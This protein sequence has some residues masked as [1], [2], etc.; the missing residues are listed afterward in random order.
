MKFIKTIFVLIV[1]CCIFSCKSY[2]NLKIDS[3][4]FNMLNEGISFNISEFDIYTFNICEKYNSNIDGTERF[5]PCP[6]NFFEV[7]VN[8]EI[9]KVEELYLLKHKTS[10][11]VVY[12]T[13]FSH[14]YIKKQ[15]GFLNDESNYKSKFYLYD[16]EY[17]FIGKYKADSAK[18]I[19]EKQR[20]KANQYW[21]PITWTNNQN[22]IQIS[23]VNIETVEN[24]G[25]L[26]EGIKLNTVFSIPFN[27]EKE[28]SYSLLN[29]KKEQLPINKI[30]FI[31]NKKN[32]IEVVFKIKDMPHGYRFIAKKVPFYSE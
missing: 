7:T 18:I 13:T 5:L 14:K 4:Y 11:L 15:K 1:A 20:A 10:N 28:S 3:D 9:K 6:K 22:L 8:E 25:N 23:E 2:R 17:I 24:G 26:N 19:F 32:E 31:R 21:K 30:Y 12:M 29:K 16:T 27:F